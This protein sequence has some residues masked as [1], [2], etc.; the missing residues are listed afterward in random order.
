MWEHR[1]AFMENAWFI[2]NEEG[3]DLIVSFAIPIDDAGNVKSLTLL[4]TPKYEFALEEFE[5]GVKVSYEDFPNDKD[6][7]LEKLAIEG[8][9]V[10]ITTDH[11]NY[12]VN[13]KNVEPKEIQ[14]S[15]RI[16]KKMNFDGRFELKVI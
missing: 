10:T 7:L 4:R 14:E 6:E 12:T 13:I 3:D 15:K 5:R 2:T 1:M 11:R 9:M 8:N 16:L